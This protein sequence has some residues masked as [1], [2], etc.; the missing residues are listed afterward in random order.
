MAFRPT[1][2]GAMSRHLAKLQVSGT[3][4]P[5]RATDHPIVAPEGSPVLML[6]A[7]LG[8]S[9]G[10]QAAQAG[11]ALFAW[12]LS[13]DTAER[14]AWYEAGC[15]FRIELVQQEA[16]NDYAAGVPEDLLI[17]DAGRTEIDPGSATAFVKA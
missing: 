3:D 2:Y 10:K 11:H 13:L 16:F 6:N 7:G 14:R 5:Q 9:T 1:T 15:P 12:F 17:V 4:L 8:M